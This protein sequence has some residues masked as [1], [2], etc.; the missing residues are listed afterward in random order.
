MKTAVKKEKGRVDLFG[1][2]FR[3]R[4]HQLSPRLLAVVSYINENREVVLERTAMEIAAATHT[5]DAT[6]VRA[7]QALGF[8]GL[9]ELKQTM[10]RWFG[11]SVTSSEK[12][13]STVNALSSDVNSSID[14]VLEGHQRA[15]EVLSRPANRAAVAQAVALLSE[16][17]QVAI[18]GIGASGILAEYTGRLFSRIG[19]PSYVMNRTGFSLAEQLINLQR[20]DVMIMMGQKSPHRE[21]MT[22]L[23]EARRLGIPTILLTQ[24]V[25]SRFSQEA[26]VVID[27]PRGG[28]NGRV[29]LHGTVLV[30]LEMLVLSVA[31]T[32][33]QRTIKSMKR[34]NELHKAI[35]KSGGKR[36]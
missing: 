15:C 12:M 18:F 32:S 27:V 4:A 2:R 11:P 36:G 17:R 25:D 21:G 35:G 5:S 22:A 30:C 8:A 23:R 20:G 6:V 26:Q 24:A 31:T 28:D 10:E 9:R 16:A 14:F 19:L 1:D 33:P 3:A 7:I 34:I 13:L 29:P